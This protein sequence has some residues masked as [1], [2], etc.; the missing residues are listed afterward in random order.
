MEIQQRAMYEDA[1]TGSRVVISDATDPHDIQGNFD[2][3]LYNKVGS[4]LVLSIV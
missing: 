4:R 2:L 1:G 3:I